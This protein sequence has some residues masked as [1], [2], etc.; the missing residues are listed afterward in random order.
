MQ[1]LSKKVLL[2]MLAFIVI[3]VVFVIVANQFINNT[4]DLSLYEYIQYSSR[5]SNEEAKYLSEKG[6]LYFSSDKNAP[7]F[8]YVEKEN[9]QYKGLVLDY[10]NALSIEIGV[11]I[12]FVP[13]VW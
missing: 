3:I 11:D 5:I 4:Y 6:T 8:A 10:V 13:H 12:E 7:P 9:G 2:A 1:I